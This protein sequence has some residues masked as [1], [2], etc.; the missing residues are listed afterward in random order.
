M[1]LKTGDSLPSIVPVKGDFDAFF[2]R[3]LADLPIE[4]DVVEAHRGA[5]LPPIDA[6][7]GALITGSPSSVTA[8][9]PWALELAR[10][11]KLAVDADRPLLGVCYGHQLLAFATGGRVITNPRGVEAGTVEVELTKDASA[12]PLFAPF[13][14]RPTIEV[15]ATHA[16]IV[17]ELPDRAVV[18]ATNEASPVQAFRLGARAYGVQFHPE[19]DEDVMRAYLV[20]RRSVSPREGDVRPT[21]AGRALLRR[22]VQ[23]IVARRLR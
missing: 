20:A 23:E 21:P 17:A 6:H 4:I 5:R 12:D 7:D 9:E 15:H 19:F 2:I 22:F 8:P 3:A 11:T 18:L 10:W 16:D 1:I 13:A 14:D